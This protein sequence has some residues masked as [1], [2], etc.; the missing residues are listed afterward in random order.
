[1]IFIYA[2]HG[3]GYFMGY[4]CCLD[5]EL[6]GVP[7]EDIQGSFAYSSEEMKDVEIYTNND[8]LLSGTL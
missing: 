1:M 3:G 7:L 2:M 5:Y 6:L 8:H 4:G